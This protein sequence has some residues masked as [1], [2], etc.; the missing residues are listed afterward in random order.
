MSTLNCTIIYFIANIDISCNLTQIFHLHHTDSHLYRWAWCG[1]LRRSPSRY[2]YVLASLE[3]WSH[4]LWLQPP[5]PWEARPG[6]L[7]TCVAPCVDPVWGQGWSFIVIGAKCIRRDGGDRISWN[8]WQWCM[9]VWNATNNLF[10]VCYLD[11]IESMHTVSQIP[12][13]GQWIIIIWHRR[14]H[15]C[16]QQKAYHW[17]TIDRQFNFPLRYICHYFEA[18]LLDQSFA[19]G[20]QLLPNR[21]FAFSASIASHLHRTFIVG[22]H[23]FPVL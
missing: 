10:I 21:A 23:T 8:N 22:N 9:I 12:A 17:W 18:L 2:F 20:L 14:I 6:N 13:F 5:H 19:N 7:P 1:L 16:P 4:P 15:V 3:Y 11:I